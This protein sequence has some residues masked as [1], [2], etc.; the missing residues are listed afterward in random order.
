MEEN[1]MLMLNYILPSLTLVVVAFQAYIMLRQAKISD[2]Q[3]AIL[4]EQIKISKEEQRARIKAPTNITLFSTGAQTGIQVMIENKGNTA[5]TDLKYYFEHE[6]IDTHNLAQIQDS[7]RNKIFERKSKQIVCIP[8]VSDSIGV[9]LY[10]GK[11]EVSKLNFNA[12]YNSNKNELEKK[13][14][15]MYIWGSISYNDAFGKYYQVPFVTIL[16]IT[17]VKGLSTIAVM[18]IEINNEQQKEIN[19]FILK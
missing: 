2:K 15:C 17:S 9:M 18:P 19:S 4:E 11:E 5:A 10:L 1:I 12:T 7:I 14:F 3:T 13:S 8:E 16:E 6:F